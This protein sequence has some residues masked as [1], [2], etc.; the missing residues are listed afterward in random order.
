M[1]KGK[2]SGVP[3]REAG[4]GAGGCCG[5]ASQKQGIPCG[6]LG[7]HTWFPPVVPKLEAGTKIREAV[8]Y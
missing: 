2:V 1:E 6:W 3:C 4:G 5:Q 8:S 7:V